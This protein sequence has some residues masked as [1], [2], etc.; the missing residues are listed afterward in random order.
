V[1]QTVIVPAI[2][3]NKY[4]LKLFDSNDESDKKQRLVDVVLASAAAPTYFLPAKV[5]DT[6]YVDGGLCCNNPAFRAVA[7]LSRE[8]VELP[9]IYVLS[10]STGAVPVTK[11]GDDFLRLHKFGW[12]RPAIDLA[13]SGSSDSAVQDGSL[14]GTIVG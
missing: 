5:G 2:S 7:E 9:R 3:I 10:V 12:I 1:H 4:K 6:Y 13:M 11:A 14:V 8:G